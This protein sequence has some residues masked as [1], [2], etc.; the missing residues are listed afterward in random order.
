MIALVLA[1]AEGVDRAARAYGY[2]GRQKG[3]SG[4]PASVRCSARDPCSGHMFSVEYGSGVSSSGSSPLNKQPR[5][6]QQL[7]CSPTT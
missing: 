4:G 6:F 3:R 2:T 5:G 7:R 1:S